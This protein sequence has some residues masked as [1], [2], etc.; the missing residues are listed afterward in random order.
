MRLTATLL[1]VLLALTPLA[2]ADEWS[3][4]YAITGK[5][6]L[7]VETSDANIRVDTWGQNT[8]EARVT[9]EHWKIG[10]GGVR[11]IER[12]MG[13]SVELEVRLPHEHHTCIIC[14]NVHSY[15]VNVEIHMPRE[16]RVNL[17]TGDGSIRLSNFK[18]DMQLESSD[19]SQ[20]IDSVDGTLRTHAGDGHIRAAGR[21]DSLD[22][23]TGDGRIEIRALTGSTMASSWDLHT[24]DGSVTLELP[25]NFA[26]DV[27]LHTGDGHISLDMPVTVEG[28]LGGNNIHGKLNGGGNLLTIHTGDGSIKL[29]KS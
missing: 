10:E 25:E 26:A 6:E 23:S 13:D 28:R 19:G 4:T 16:G 5:P 18:G 29:Q 14:V 15:R 7:R 17:R 3:K 27:D 12:Q 21:F 9:S 1:F 22:A 2:R 24:G 20:E 11:V 8:I